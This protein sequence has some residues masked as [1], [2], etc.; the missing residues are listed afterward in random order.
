MSKAMEVMSSLQS[1]VGVFIDGFFVE[2]VLS[3]QRFSLVFALGSMMAGLAGMLISPITEA[4]IGMGGEII[5]TAFVVI[6]L[7][8]WKLFLKRM[9]ISLL[10]L[11]H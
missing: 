5:I 8:L 9:M 10:K 4:S 11:N 1:V 6:I 3:D 2:G 7:R